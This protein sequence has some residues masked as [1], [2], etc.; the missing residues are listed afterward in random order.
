MSSDIFRRD[1]LVLLA[2]NAALTPDGRAYLIANL[3]RMSS[4]IFRSEVVEA[5]QERPPAKD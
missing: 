2:R 5:L 3:D 4:D 1:V